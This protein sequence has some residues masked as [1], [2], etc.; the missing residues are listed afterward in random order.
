MR[1]PGSGSF[2]AQCF[3]TVSNH[4]DGAWHHVVAV[5]ATAGM[6]VYLDGAEVCTNAHGDE[7]HY[8]ANATQLWVGQHA[9]LRGSDRFDGNLDE[10]RMYQPCALGGRRRLARRRSPLS[11]RASDRRPV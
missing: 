11:D 1:P 4:L 7:V 5:S 9:L 6:K 8:T 3:A 2:F 10:L